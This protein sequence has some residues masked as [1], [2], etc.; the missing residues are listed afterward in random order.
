MNILADY[1]GHGDLYYSLHA[2]FEN[3]LG[4]NL[5]CPN[6]DEWGDY[7][8]FFHDPVVR[9]I[10]T[11]EEMRKNWVPGCDSHE[12]I[13]GVHCYRRKMEVNSGY[14][15]QK[16]IGFKKFLEMDWDIILTTHYGHEE[17]FCN[18]VKKHAPKAK[19]IRQINNIVE[20][21]THCKNV[22]WGMNTPVPE[23]INY[24]RYIPEH[25][26]GYH[27]TPPQNHNT[28][29]SFMDD[30]PTAVDA[31]NIWNGLK[32]CLPD[33]KFYMHGRGGHDILLAPPLMPMSMRDSAFI[34]HVK[35]HGGGG[36]IPRQALSCGRPMIISKKYARWFNELT[37]NLWEDGVN[38]IDVDLHKVDEVA[39]I[40][41][42]WSEPEVHERICKTVAE[43]AKKDMDFVREA[44]NIKAW[45]ENIK[46]GVE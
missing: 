41:K 37:V 27:Y 19:L 3:R 40:I 39:K 45:I 42:E 6:L 5:Y 31:F 1:V 33:F 7:I 29:K 32:A 26:D 8:N 44:E 30:L 35:P 15:T 20:S 21:P 38:V 9:K 12:F 17:K 4:Y 11:V 22:L 46:P 23:G 24:I 18:L 25:Y 13:D 2:L 14:Y 34:W 36:F 16:V 28:I 10:D 43:K